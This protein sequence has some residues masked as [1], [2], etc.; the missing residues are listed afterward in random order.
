[1]PNLNEILSQYTYIVNL[2]AGDVTPRRAVLWR[3][4][5]CQFGTL[6]LRRKIALEFL[7]FAY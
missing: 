6:P 3:G 7:H 5:A 4:S 1:L 2:F